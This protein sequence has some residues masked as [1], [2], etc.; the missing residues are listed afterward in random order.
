M[1]IILTC[2]FSA[3]LVSVQAQQAKEVGA[4]EAKTRVDSVSKNGSDLKFSVYVQPQF[5]IA[6]KKGA[7][8]YIGDD[9]PENVNNR[10]LLRRG[11]FK[12]EYSKRNQLGDPTIEMVFQI[13]ATQE[14][15]EVKDV[16]GRIY[17]NKFQLFSL[18]AGIFSIPFGYEVELSSSKRESPERG[19]M[20]QTIFDSERDLGAIIS[21]SPQ[22]KDHPLRYLKI[23]A[24][25]FNGPGL[26]PIADFDSHKDFVLRAGLKPVPITKNISLSLDASYYNGGMLQTNKYVALLNK[27]RKSFEIDSSSNNTGKIAPRKYYGADAQLKIKNG[28]GFTEL[29]GEMITGKQTSLENSSETPGEL[30]FEDQPLFVRNF[31]GGYFYFLQNFF[32]EKNQLAVKFDYYDPNILVSAKDI[33]A[34]GKKLTAADIKYSTL[35]IGFIRKI[36]DV[37]KLTLWFDK[38][39]NEKTQLPGYNSDISDNIFTCRLQF[40]F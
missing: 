27:D 40:K 18:T 3:L 39:W 26:S 22:Q 21:F 25:V 5:Q 20:S 15:V 4:F 32:T 17:E 1:K 11:R 38:V 30:P 12:V 9:F 33:G 29:R 35:G 7:E 28:C 36:N 6:S 13:N 16:W 10:F 2:L 23:D 31:A 37:T 19:R 14:G 8:T 34:A 24:G